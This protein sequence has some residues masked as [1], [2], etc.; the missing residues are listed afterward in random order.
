MSQS[1]ALEAIQP[2]K[3]RRVA[4]AVMLVPIFA[5]PRIILIA[6][7]LAAKNAN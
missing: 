1:R 2:L 7:Q 5:Q 4:L 3:L 6:R